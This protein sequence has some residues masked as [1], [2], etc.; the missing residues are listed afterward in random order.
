MKTFWLE[1]VTPK[2]RLFSGEVTFVSAPAVTGT[3]GVLANHMPLF[4][5]LEKG[6]VKVKDRA[7]KVHFFEIGKGVLEVAQGK[8]TLLVEDPSQAAEVAAERVAEAREKIKEIIKKRKELERKGRGPEGL[9]RSF[10]DM[11]I[12]AKRRLRSRSPFM[13]EEEKGEG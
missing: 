10:L 4:T 6:R 9:R 13:V 3:V 1:V 2:K 8:V 5:P 7:G 11:K 12:V